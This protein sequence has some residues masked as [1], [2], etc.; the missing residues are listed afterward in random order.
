MSISS[1]QGKA[2]FFEK[3]KQKTF[4]YGAAHE[5][6]RMRRMAGWAEKVLW[7]FLSRKN[8]LPYFMSANAIAAAVTPT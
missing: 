5:W 8:M 3:K 1:R 6:G 2:F 4:A 7:F